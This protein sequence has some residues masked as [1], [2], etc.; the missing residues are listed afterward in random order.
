MSVYGINV[1]KLNEYTWE[2]KESH[3]SESDGYL[4]DACIDR[5]RIVL[6]SIVVHQIMLMMEMREFRNSELLS[7]LAKYFPTLQQKHSC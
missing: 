3:L 5:D 7:W 2:F 4:N 6:L 1:L